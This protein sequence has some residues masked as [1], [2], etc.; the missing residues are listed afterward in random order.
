MKRHLARR[1][2]DEK[3]DQRVVEE[4]LGNKTAM[5]THAFSLPMNLLW[6]TEEEEQIQKEKQGEEGKQ[7]T[8]GN[9]CANPHRLESI[10]KVDLSADGKEQIEDKI[11]NLHK[12]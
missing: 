8:R 5:L 6:S 9:V 1:G 2:Q 4:A 11:G 7:L 12:I 3:E 10:S